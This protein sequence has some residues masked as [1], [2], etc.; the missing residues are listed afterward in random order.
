MQ[1]LYSPHI[2]FKTL[3]SNLHLWNPFGKSPTLYATLNKGENAHTLSKTHTHAHTYIPKQLRHYKTLLNFTLEVKCHMCQY[4]TDVLQLPLGS[5]FICDT[6]P[7][8]NHPH[9]QW[10]HPGALRLP[11]C[12]DNIRTFEVSSLNQKISHHTQINR[13]A[14]VHLRS[15]VSTFKHGN[16]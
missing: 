13:P 1:H 14:R 3:N 16:N 8:P 5:N 15:Q 11:S 4:K 10:P 6:T 7:F 2:T 9:H 12:T